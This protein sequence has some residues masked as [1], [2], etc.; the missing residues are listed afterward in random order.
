VRR[1]YARMNRGCQE[2]KSKKEKKEK[3]SKRKGSDKAAAGSKVRDLASGVQ[4]W[5]KP[6]GTESTGRWFD[7]SVV[8]VEKKS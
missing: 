6:K 4:G 8:G 5:T 1:L 7:S 3:G 2:K